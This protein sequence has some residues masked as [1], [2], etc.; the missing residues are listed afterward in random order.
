MVPVV[1]K[2][3]GEYQELILYIVL[4]T[5]SID[6]GYSR[7]VDRRSDYHI[8]IFFT[9]TVLTVGSSAFCVYDPRRVEVI[10]EK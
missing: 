6:K 10:S 2:S 1:F 5:T 4:L 9:K 7:R 8:D 3:S